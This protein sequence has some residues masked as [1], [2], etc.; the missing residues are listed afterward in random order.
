MSDHE[1]HHRLPRSRGGSNDP[2]NISVVR[3]KYHSAYHLLFGNMTAKEMASLLNSV[4]I[5]PDVRFVVRKRRR[6]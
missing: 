1:K 2:R 3:S 5:D 6:K 4:W